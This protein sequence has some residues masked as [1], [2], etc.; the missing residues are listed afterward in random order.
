M[1]QTPPT[2]LFSRAAKR[3]GLTGAASIALVMLG[4]WF[5]EGVACVGEPWALVKILLVFVFMVTLLRHQV[6]VG[7]VLILSA[8]VLGLMFSLSVGSI[9]RVLVFDLFGHDS[10]LHHLLF[11][12]VVL[13]VVIF[14]INA[15]GRLMEAAGTLWRLIAS[16]DDLI[17]DSRYVMATIP[18]AIGLLPMPGGAMLSAPFVGELG[19]KLEMGAEDKTLV[20]YWFRHIFEYAWPLYPAVIMASELTNR[21]LS[22]VMLAHAPMILVAVGVGMVMLHVRLERKSLAVGKQGSFWGNVVV[23]LEAVWPVAVVASVVGFSPYIATGKVKDL[24]FPA[25]LIAVNVALIFLTKLS[26]AQVAEVVRK[27]FSW[28]TVVLVIGIY[29]LR[30]MFERTNVTAGMPGLLADLGIPSTLIIFLVPFVVG[31][32]TG[33][34][35]AAVSTGFPALLALL[36]T[37]GDVLIAYC[38]AF[39]GVLVSPVHLCLIL[40]RDYFRANLALVYKTLIPMLAAVVA[41]M[42]AYTTFVLG[43]S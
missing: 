2:D 27:S 18:A 19:D 12:A 37:N 9:S 40:T 23:L 8:A 4:L 43:I 28:H 15:L 31:L 38:G 21:P 1:P 20:N 14:A 17:K 32:L 39:V 11:K 30:A 13:I 22:T 26:R 5:R 24:L 16:L 34:N 29:I 36:N 25:A 10:G 41:I 42:L 3:I 7:L 33:Y 6:D 35:V